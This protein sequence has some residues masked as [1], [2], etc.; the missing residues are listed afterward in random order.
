MYSA[1][2]RSTMSTPDFASTT[3]YNQQGRGGSLMPH[4]GPLDLVCATGEVNSL[5]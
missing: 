4:P 5:C 3:S 2:H 1:G